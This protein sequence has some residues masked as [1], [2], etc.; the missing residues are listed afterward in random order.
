MRYRG[1]KDLQRSFCTETSIGQYY[2]YI[3]YFYDDIC[4]QTHLWESKWKTSQSQKKEYT[5]HPKFLLNVFHWKSGLF[6]LQL[7]ADFLAFSCALYCYLRQFSKLHSP[8]ISK[9]FSIHC[10]IYSICFQLH[11]FSLFLGL[12]FLVNAGR[13]SRLVSTGK[14]VKR[15]INQTY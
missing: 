8:Y 14:Q 12:F 7:R 1:Y 6:K 3:G 15:K 11:Q 5:H 4:L 9:L 10:T 13:T 2:L